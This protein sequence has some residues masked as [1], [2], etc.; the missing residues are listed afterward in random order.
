MKHVDLGRV[1]VSAIGTIVCAV[2]NAQAPAT[3]VGVSG[4]VLVLQGRTELPGY[5][6]DFDHFAVDLHLVRG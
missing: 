6:G 5:T 1:L 3:A 2:A 4:P